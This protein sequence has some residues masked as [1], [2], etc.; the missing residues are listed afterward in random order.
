MKNTIT[1][2]EFLA[3]G[4]S[5]TTTNQYT[6]VRAWEFP[7]ML[8]YTLPTAQ[9]DGRLR[10]F[11]EAGPSFRTQQDAMATEPSQFGVSVDIGAALHLG[12]IRIAPTV[13]YT[14]WERESIY[15]KYATKPAQIEFLTSVAYQTESGSRRLAGRKLEIDRK[16]VV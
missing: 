6:A 9:S 12:R 15:P 16:S 4:S 7:V 11:L 13:R 5:R 1:F 10:P 8:K 2:T 3:N 14:R